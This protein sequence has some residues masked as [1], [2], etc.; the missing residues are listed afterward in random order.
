[1]AN[2]KDPVCG[3]TV[4]T[5]TAAGQSTFRGTTYYFCSEDCKKTFDGDPA[6]YANQTANVGGME[7]HEPPFTNKGFPAPK[8]GS[9]ASGGLENEL[10]PEA[11]EGHRKG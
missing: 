2:V 3:M 8:F 11:H 5:D 7:R 6:R 1:M 10:M 4:E 9:A